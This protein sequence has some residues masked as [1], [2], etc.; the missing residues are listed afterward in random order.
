M[1]QGIRVLMEGNTAIVIAHR[2]STIQG[3]D[4]IYVLHRGR[5]VEAGTHSELLSLGGVYHRLYHLQYQVQERP[6][7]AAG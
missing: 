3:V 4:R 1:Q 7:L 2:L 6:A 5:I